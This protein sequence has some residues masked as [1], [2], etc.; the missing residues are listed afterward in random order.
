MYPKMKY[1]GGKGPNLRVSFITYS[2]KGNIILPLTSDRG[3]IQRGLDRLKYSI[4]AGTRIPHKGFEKA[5]VQL[6]RSNS[7]A[8]QIPSV[9]ISVISDILDDRRYDKAKAEADKARNSGATIYTVGVENYDYVIDAEDLYPKIKK[10]EVFCRFKFNATGIVDQRAKNVD[11]TGITCGVPVIYEAGREIFVKVSVDNGKSFLDISFRFTSIDCG[12]LILCNFSH[13]SCH[14]VSMTLPPSSDQGSCINFNLLKVLCAQGHWD[15]KIGLQPSLDNLPIAYCSQCHHPEAWSASRRSPSPLSCDC[16]LDPQVASAGLRKQAHSPGELSAHF[17][18]RQIPPSG[19]LPCRA[20]G[21]PALQSSHPATD[22]WWNRYFAQLIQ[23]LLITMAAGKR[24]PTSPSAE[25]RRQ[26]CESE[27]DQSYKPVLLEKTNCLGPEAATGRG[28]QDVLCAELALSTSAGKPRPGKP[29]PWKACKGERPSA[30][31]ELPRPQERL[32]G[33]HA[34]D[35]ESEVP[36]G[37][38]D[39]QQLTPDVPRALASGVWPGAARGEQRSAFS[40]PTKRP[41]ERPVFQDTLGE[42]S[43]LLHA[44]DVPC[45]NGLS[46]S[47]LVVRDLWN[48]QTV[49]QN[50]LLCSAF[51]GAP[52]L[53]LEPAQARGGPIPS[54]SRSLPSRAILP[55]TLASLGLSTQNWCARCSCSFRLTS[56]LVFHMRSHHKKE[57]VGPDLH[58]KLRRQ[59]A[60]AC[61]VCHEHFRERHHLSRHMTSHS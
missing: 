9:I 11:K 8:V 57:L 17:T 15:P 61:P 40:K 37:H 12:P 6:E 32:G 46:T 35:R 47:K 29:L 31:M 60:L 5:N 48:L 30:F 43:G 1:R 41:A 24:T 49:S 44:M 4:P 19:G 25:N 55:P 2:C 56:D 51:P 52:T 28:A 34:Q 38:P 3:E 53:W 7:G 58:P 36:A 39:P 21:R 33:S 50:T 27:Q 13:P 26:L 23:V 22:G 42:L 45:W 16:G 20:P 14:Q 18:L 59:E 10:E 54:A